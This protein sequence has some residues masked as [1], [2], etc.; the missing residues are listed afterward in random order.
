MYG[1][2][3][4]EKM[5]VAREVLYRGTGQQDQNLT[6][7]GPVLVTGLKDGEKFTPL[8]LKKHL[9][10]NE[11]GYTDSDGKT[12]VECSSSETADY[13]DGYEEHE[14]ATD[15][16]TI[17]EE[18]FDSSSSS[19]ETIQQTREVEQRSSEKQRNEQTR[20]TQP[21]DTQQQQRAE[22]Q[23][24]EEERAARNAALTRA[25]LS[26]S[27]EIALDIADTYCQRNGKGDRKIL[28]GCKGPGSAH[29]N[30]DDIKGVR[31][32]GAGASA[33]T[34]NHYAGYTTSPVKTTAF[35]QAS[36]AQASA[37][38][39][40]IEGI[41]AN[42]KA[43]LC[44]ANAGASIGLTG[45]RA[46]ASAQYLTAEV[47][48]KNTPLQAHVELVGAGAEAGASVGYIGA[49][50]GAHLAEVRGGP[51]RA[52]FGLKFGGGIRNGIPEV[53]AGP[54]T[55]PACCIM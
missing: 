8:H 17:Q 42:A 28:G 45:A 13:Y 15:L 23:R 12:Y 46:G 19:S 30:V 7:Q 18:D 52:R 11:H 10:E 40:L 34:E 35:A 43:S 26:S 33:T 47:G 48:L 44:S 22:E 38:A 1:R 50:A 6:G 24:N 41:E 9:Q 39:Y 21:R 37:S 29:V 14:I 36:A 31:I 54:V 2:N 27:I 25:V 16:S 4:G 32:L 20:D 5:L 51:F 53:D 55:I 3:H 49:S